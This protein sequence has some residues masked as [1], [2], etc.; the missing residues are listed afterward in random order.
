MRASVMAMS[1]VATGLLAAG[2]AVLSAGYRRHAWMQGEIEDALA[3]YRLLEGHPRVDADRIAFLGNSHGG[4]IVLGAGP[5]TNAIAVVNYCGV[6]DA[7]SMFRFLTSSPL[8]AR[9]PLIREALDDLKKIAGGTFDE[10]PEVYRAM[11]P[12]YRVW[13]MRCPVLIVHGSQDGVVPV[14]HAYILRDALEAAECP[15]EMHIYPRM[16]HS[17]PFQNRPEARD[18]VALTVAFLKKCIPSCLPQMTLAGSAARPEVQHA[19]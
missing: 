6:T 3:A 7:E 16:P 15:Y 8:R 19:R 13:E 12:A 11:S 9:M 5:R 4:S 1:R 18:A 14:T 17:F 10:Y 2:Y